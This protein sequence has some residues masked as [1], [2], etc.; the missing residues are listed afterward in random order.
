VTLASSKT[1]APRAL[2]NYVD[3]Q[4]ILVYNSSTSA[5]TATITPAE[6]T[7]DG[8]AS[9][10]LTVPAKGIVGA[11]RL[12]A[13]AWGSVQPGIVATTGIRCYQTGGVLYAVGIGMSTTGE[14]DTTA[15]VAMTAVA[16]GGGVT[17]ATN[18]ITIA[19][20]TAATTKFDPTTIGAAGQVWYVALS[21]CGLSAPLSTSYTLTTEA[22]GSRPTVE[23]AYVAGWVATDVPSTASQ[24]SQGGGPCY[25]ATGKTA[26]YAWGT[27]TTGETA[28]N[29]ANDI[30]ACSAFVGDN[31]GRI[32][33]FSTARDA[34]GVGVASAPTTGVV[35]H[36]CITAG[37]R[38]SALGSDAV[39]GDMRIT[40][41]EAGL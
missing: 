11:V 28:A 34:K 15:P 31:V 38:G 35:T 29:A 13:S 26:V 30:V 5:I 37:V 14:V 41:R 22:V 20:G 8:G 9:V 24:V 25:S 1:V 3:G 6:G 36:L 33:T 12:S 32:C 18:E 39:F 10:A 16:G 2:S 23:D 7:I 21:S 27:N 19:S 4:R 17:L 40:F